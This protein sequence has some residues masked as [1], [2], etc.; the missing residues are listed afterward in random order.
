MIRA[1][2]IGCVAAALIAMAPAAAA[3]I[4][5]AMAQLP[6]GGTFVDDDASIHQEWIEAIAAAGIT[7]GCNPPDSD[8]YCPG[9]PVTRGQMAALLARALHLPPVEGPSSF[10]D[11]DAS[12]F[13]DDIDRIATV[14]IT[15][16]CNPPANDRYCPSAP[17]TR[18]QMAALL[19]RG[20][21]YPTVT[22]NR[23]TDDD[24]SV[25]EGSIDAIAAEGITL[26][27]NP[28]ANDHYCPSAAVT[29]A[30]MA[31]FLGRALGL[32]PV[33]VPPRPV[34]VDVVP[35]GEWGAA[36]PTGSFT[37]H[38]IDE[39]TIHHAGTVT[40]VTG[41][42]Q[43]QG[44]QGY[45][46]SLG[47]PD[48]A[49]HF[50]VGRDGMIYE[51]RPF[52]A[53]GDTATAYDPTGHLL[54]VVEGNFDVSTPTSAQLENVAQLVAWGSQMFD[55]GVADAMGHRDHAA[56][57]CPGDA[58]YAAIHDGSLATRAQELLDAGGVQMLLG[59]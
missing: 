12:I 30:Q 5:P 42:Q 36:S 41:P 34:T 59:G 29:R 37:N 56:T 32:S 14:G 43:F 19:Q 2:A 17:V 16:G 11:A 47:W 51:G 38:T 27:C 57:T 7:N 55:V 45:H 4:V 13:A 40:G 39:L 50:I 48:L 9:A 18:G 35:R 49:Y 8:R 15:R 22:T 23:F 31:T 44:W 52:T 24:G 25:F 10:T 26:G 53:V 58:L 46:Q 20:F 28:P 1:T 33:A 3:P 6:P 54:I 21:G